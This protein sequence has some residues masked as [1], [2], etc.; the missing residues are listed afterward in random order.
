MNSPR[1]RR[2]VRQANPDWVFLRTWGVST[3][4]GGEDRRALRLPG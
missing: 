2:Q 1:N 3:P 4:G